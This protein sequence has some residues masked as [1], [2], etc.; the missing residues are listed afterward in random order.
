[1]HWML[2]ALGALAVTG[3]AAI[4][5][6]AITT[7]W[8]PPWGRRR[9]LRPKLWGYGALVGAVGMSLYMFLG[10]FRGPDADITP[11]AMTGLALFFVG[12]VLQMAGQ[13][14]GRVTVQP[15]TTDR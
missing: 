8:V 10:P 11:Y 5:I 9:V 4:G 3:L 1:M 6:A 7:G 13:R 2:V 14:P 15:M 12:V